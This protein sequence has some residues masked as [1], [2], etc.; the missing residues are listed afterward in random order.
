MSSLFTSFSFSKKEDNKFDISSIIISFI[1]VCALSTFCGLIFVINFTGWFVI[2]IIGGTITKGRQGLFNYLSGKS[3]KKNNLDN[4]LDH[5]LN[6]RHLSHFEDF[7]SSSL[8]SLPSM[9]S[10]RSISK[11]NKSIINSNKFDSLLSLDFSFVGLTGDS[12]S[13]KSQKNLKVLPPSEYSQKRNERHTP[14][15]PSQLG[16]NRPKEWKSAMDY[17]P[18]ERH[19]HQPKSKPKLS[20]TDKMIE[21]T[22]AYRVGKK[23]SGWINGDAEEYAIKKQQRQMESMMD[24]TSINSDDDPFYSNEPIK[25]LNVRL[26]QE[27]PKIT[28]KNRR[29][30]HKSPASS[31]QHARQYLTILLKI[32]RGMNL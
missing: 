20:V 30:S 11:S 29:I 10:Y 3:G 12:K 15:I 16:P 5:R 28:K 8:N 17:Y 6:S 32:K 2:S 4:M 1:T 26:D 25:D 18:S 31:L 9:P 22:A 23:C 14:D 13:K 7:H 19:S 27:R 24:C 21:S